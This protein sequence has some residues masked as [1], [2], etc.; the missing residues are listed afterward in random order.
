MCPQPTNFSCGKA[1]PLKIDAPP[2]AS[3]VFW[4]PLW[5]S[6][7]SAFMVCWRRVNVA[8]Q[9]SYCL[10]ALNFIFNG[11]QR[12][13]LTVHT[14]IKTIRGASSAPKNNNMPHTLLKPVLGLKFYLFISH[15]EYYVTF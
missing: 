14:H 12:Q 6:N 15:D 3:L 11:I 8:C 5:H 4:N 7:C 9:V 13:N 10:P 1:T 2:H